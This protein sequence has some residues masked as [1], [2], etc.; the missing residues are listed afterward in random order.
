MSRPSFIP[1]L[2]WL[3][4]LCSPALQG[5]AAAQCDTP[6]LSVH[7]DSIFARETGA[8]IDQRLGPETVRLRALFD[9]TSYR[10]LRTD[11]ADT[12]C[13]Q[14]VAFILPVGRV[15]HVRPLATHGNLV[16][17]ELA[18]F[19]GARAVMRTQLKMSKGGLLL[20]IGSQNPQDANIT[21]IRVDDPGSLPPNG[22]FGA[23]T[24]VATP[25]PSAERPINPK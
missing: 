24:A 12:A 19:A 25:L 15:L 14:E 11:E 22:P 20:L 2:F 17:L 16:A 4:A 3:L 13:G 5:R 7:V 23:A 10:L 18:L 21:S 9:Y 8:E 1:F 6:L